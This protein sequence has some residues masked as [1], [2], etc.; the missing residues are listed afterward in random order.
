MVRKVYPTV[1][2]VVVPDLSM[3]V[4]VPVK[5][6]SSESMVTSADWPLEIERMSVSSTETSMVIFLSG[7][8]V[9]AFDFVV[10]VS[11]DED[12]EDWFP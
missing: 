11:V 3:S 6:F 7:Q 5:V 10:V 12:E 1:P 8:M 4:I 2:S 9:N